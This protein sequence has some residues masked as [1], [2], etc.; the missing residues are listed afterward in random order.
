MRVSAGGAMFFG[1]I[2]ADYDRLRPSPPQDAVRWL[3][4]P[5]CD[6]AV[7]L[8]AGTGLLSSALAGWAG[9]VVSVEPDGRMA[10]VLRQRSPG[11][12][13]PAGPRR[14]VP[15]QGPSARPLLTPA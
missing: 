6:V 13:I 11:V 4:P 2:A 15:L 10:A 7:D 14:A 12:H 8:G 1:S 3:L 5:R 9:E